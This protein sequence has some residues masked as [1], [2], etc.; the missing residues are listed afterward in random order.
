VYVLRVYVGMLTIGQIK[1]NM[2]IVLKFKVL[3]ILLSIFF[4]NNT[5]YYFKDKVIN[6]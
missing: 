1:I 4:I 3:P 5:W 6:K 2:S